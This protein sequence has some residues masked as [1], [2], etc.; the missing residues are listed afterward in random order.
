M[1]SETITTLLLLAIAALLWKLSTQVHKVL[2]EFR[3]IR[4]SLA[5]P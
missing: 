1:D 2:A 5:R 3:H 4:R